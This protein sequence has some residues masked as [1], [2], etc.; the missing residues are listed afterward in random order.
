MTEQ[1]KKSR[2]TRKNEF[3]EKLRESIANHE[4]LEV[5]LTWGELQG[6]VVE[7][8]KDYVIFNRKERREIKRVINAPKIEGTPDQTEK[9]TEMITLQ[10]TVRTEDI[11]AVSRVLS[12][13]AVND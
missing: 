3:V 9:V 12:K 6:E 5:I 1:I 7:V 8:H 2:A 11:N 13:V 4:Q 10:I